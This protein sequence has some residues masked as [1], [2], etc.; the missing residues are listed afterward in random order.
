MEKKKKKKFME[1]LGVMNFI[2]ILVGI[3]LLVFTVEMIR[4]YKE[5][6]SIPDTLVTCVFTA[7]GGECGIMGWIKTTKEKRKSAP[8]AISV[9]DNDEIGD[10][11]VLG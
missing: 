11:E 4:L 10:E 9:Q 3:S 1:R 8:D 7:L 2:L 6:G 5:F